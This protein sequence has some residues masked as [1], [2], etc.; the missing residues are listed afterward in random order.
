MRQAGQIISTMKKRVHAA[1]VIQRSRHACLMRR[2]AMI[3]IKAMRLV[4]FNNVAA[5]IQKIIR[6]FLARLKYPG[7]ILNRNGRLQLAA[8]KIMRAWV[9][10]K[11]AKRLQILLDDNRTKVYTARLFKIRSVRIGIEEDIKE[12]RVDAGYT[13]EV[14]N[15]IKIRMKE[16]DQFIIE[17]DMRIPIIQMDMAKLTQEDFEKGWAEAYGHEYEMLNHQSSLAKEEM[18]LMRR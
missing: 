11:Y 2:E 7:M 17:A 9:N 8:K 5:T 16:I 4:Y 3:T 15:K 6:R 1:K 10:F 14:I 18:R 13:G 12:I